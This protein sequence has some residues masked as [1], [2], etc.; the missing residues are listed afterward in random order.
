MEPYNRIHIASNKGKGTKSD[1]VSLFS[2]GQVTHSVSPDIGS[3]VV[4]KAVF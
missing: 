1:C 3:A 4:A 2:A